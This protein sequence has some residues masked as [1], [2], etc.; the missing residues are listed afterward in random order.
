MFIPDFYK[1]IILVGCT[2]S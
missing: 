1:Q 2:W